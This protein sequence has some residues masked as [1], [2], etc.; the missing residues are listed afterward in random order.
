MSLCNGTS[1]ILHCIH[2]LQVKRFGNPRQIDLIVADVGG[3]V[4]AA[5]PEAQIE[6][7]DLL[8]DGCREAV[9]GGNMDAKVL[10]R[11]NLFFWIFNDDIMIFYF[12]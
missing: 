9:A 4:E 10:F 2:V 3:T 11:L 6:L 5:H 8:I 7:F 12:S 1:L